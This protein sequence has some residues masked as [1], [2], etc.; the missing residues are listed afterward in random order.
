MRCSLSTIG[1]AA[2]LL[3]CPAAAADEVEVAH[4]ENAASLTVLID[5]REAVVWQFA[6]EL[7]IPHLGP[8]RSPS[9][10]LLTVQHPEP[11]PHHRSVWIADRVQLEDGPVV[12]FYHCQKNYRDPESPDR[13]FEHFI[14]QQGKPSWKK[15][16]GQVSVEVSLQWIVGG[17]GPVLDDKRSFEITALGEGEYLLDLSWK[18]VAA[19]G[20]VRFHSDW[21]HYAWPYVRMHPRFS[22]QQGGVITDDQGRRGQEETNEKYARWIDYS[23]EVDGTTEG[24]AVFVHP[25]GARPKWLTRE[26][27]TFGPR[28]RDELSGTGFLLKKGEELRGRVGILVHRGDAE[29]GRVAE[30]Y[31][32][33]AE[34]E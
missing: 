16:P 14:R 9:G 21:V 31:R 27:G 2:L 8:L 5:G 24:L 3:A 11:F 6:K 25:D 13:G 28:R 4:D 10:E 7:A 15:K 19:H 34:G 29:S 33:Y 20:D 12:D 22:G 18:L 1:L 30:R 17:Q 26:Y 23:N 32:A